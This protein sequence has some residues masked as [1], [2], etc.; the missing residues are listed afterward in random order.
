MMEQFL[1]HTL[2]ACFF[3]TNTMGTVLG[4][5]GVPICFF[6]NLMGIFIGISEVPNAARARSLCLSLFLAR[7]LARS[8]CLSLRSNLLGKFLRKRNWSRRRRRR[9]CRRRRRRWCR[10]TWGWGLLNSAKSVYSEFYI[11]NVLGH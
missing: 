5:S 11:V 10:R 1:I 7:S 3:I 2:S 6:T 4:M 8:L 9:W